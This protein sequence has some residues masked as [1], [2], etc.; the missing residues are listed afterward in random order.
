MTLDRLKKYQAYLNTLNYSP[1]TIKT[2]RLAVLQYYNYM[3]KIGKELETVTDEDIYILINQ[4][5]KEYKYTSINLKLSSIKHY[6]KFNKIE[7]P[8]DVFIRNERPQLYPMS[9]NQIKLFNKWILLKNDSIRLP[10]KTMLNT[11]IRVNELSKL[12]LDDYMIINDKYYIKINNT[13]NYSSRLIPISKDLFKETIEYYNKNIFF[14]TVFDF[15]KRNY[16]YHIQQF[17]DLFGLKVTLHTLRRTYATYLQSQGTPIQ[18]IQKLLGHKNISTTMIY[19]KIT[20]E[21]IQ[22]FEPVD[23]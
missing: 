16:Q 3:D 8:T 12:K 7:F 19:I 4:L 1:S 14:G 6:Y 22:K 2:Y 21:Q 10:L 23:I 18:V 17:S 13:K 5:K 20:D 15:T 11:G 9:D